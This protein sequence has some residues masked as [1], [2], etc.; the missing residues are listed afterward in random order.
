MPPGNEN[1]L[2]EQ[3]WGKW[4]RVHSFNLR[5][6]DSRE[7]ASASVRG[8][9][10]RGSRP[11]LGA[12][13]GPRMTARRD[14]AVTT[15][16][17]RPR[18]E[19]APRSQKESCQTWCLCPASRRARRDRLGPGGGRTA[20]GSSGAIRP[21]GIFVAPSSWAC[22]EHDTQ[23]SRRQGLEQRCRD[24]GPSRPQ[25]H[26]TSVMLPPMAPPTARADR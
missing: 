25:S 5:S 16:P 7:M 4:S 1:F 12:G 3:F 11:S 6:S 15:E 8:V 22:P 2:V 19:P 23:C 24:Q 17:P 10:G 18:P 21:A 20:P 9:G 14:R 13:P 26:L